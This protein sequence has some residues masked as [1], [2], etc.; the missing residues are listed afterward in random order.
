MNP[1]RRTAITIG[2]LLICAIACGIFSSVPALDKQDYLAGVQDI[3]TR[4]LV[5]IFFQALIAILYV[6]IAVLLYPV[7]RLA[8]KQAALAYLSFRICGAAFLFTGIVSLLLLLSLGRLY[9]EADPAG[10]SQFVLIGA[11]LR[12]TRD[13]LNHIG[14]ILPWSI[15]GLFLYS[16]MFKT[17]LIPRWLSVW[18]LVA[19]ALTLVATMLFMLDRI[20]LV[21]V[22]YLA[23]NVPAALLELVLAVY[24]IARGFLPG[25]SQKRT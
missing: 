15:G 5:A 25:Y 17:G 21:T 11:L 20:Q 22:I 1:T 2:I 12:Q 3:E 16:S 19:T 9:A 18:G 4:I 6:A 7:I 14:M 24:L 8:H 23:L 13:W 10:K